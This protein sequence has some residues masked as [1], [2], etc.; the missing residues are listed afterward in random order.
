MEHD[1]T[2]LLND[3]ERDMTTTRNIVEELDRVEGF[4]E[5]FKPPQ[6]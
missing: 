1:R 2:V 5:N 6:Q 3:V 4:H